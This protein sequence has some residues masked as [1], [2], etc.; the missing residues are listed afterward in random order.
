MD[1]GNIVKSN[2]KGGEGMILA[3]TKDGKRA[4]VKVFGHDAEVWRPLD[5]MTVLVDSWESCWKCGGS[6][7]FYLP[8]PGPMGN[9]TV[10][11]VYQGTTGICFA[12]SGKGKQDNADRLRNHYYWHRAEVVDMAVAEAERGEFESLERTA[13]KMGK[14]LPGV[15]Y[16]AEPPARKPEQG[17]KQRPKIKSKAKPAAPAMSDTDEGSR[18]IDCKG[19]GCLHRDDTM[20]PW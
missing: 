16:D 8:G 14:V 10:N 2:A 4:K 15:K 12:C 1:K 17:P 3:L 11:G 5:S 19:C 6:G 13:A 18:L 20:C 7:K 9:A